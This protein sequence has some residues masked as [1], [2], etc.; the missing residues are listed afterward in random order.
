MWAVEAQSAAL[1]AALARLPLALAG[2]LAALRAAP[3]PPAL[4]PALAALRA[5]DPRF[6]SFALTAVLP[7]V[8]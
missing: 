4:A 3:A 8:V 2:P 7:L 5:L 6:A 1:D